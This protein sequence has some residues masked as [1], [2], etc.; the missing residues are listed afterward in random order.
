MSF[1]SWLRSARKKSHPATKA[2]PAVD[3]RRS[4]QVWR[5]LAKSDP[6]WAV[7]SMPEYRAGHMTDEAR[8]AFFESGRQHIDHVLS[9]CSQLNPGFKPLTAFDFGCGVGR[10]SVAMLRNGIKVTAIDI[11]PDMLAICRKNC[12]EVEGSEVQF[13]VSDDTLSGLSGTADLIVS[14]ITFQH[15]HPK[16]G[17]II[18]RSLLQSLN[19][20]GMFSIYFLLGEGKDNGPVG[21]GTDAIEVEIEMNDYSLNKIMGAVESCCDSCHFEFH[22][23]GN[24]MGANIYGRKR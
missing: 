1:T 13:V 21:F 17:M 16:R 5:E 18:F 10:L 8:A 24:R 22:R 7:L 12:E 14:T 15:I 11:S 4:D 20:G 19:S 6:Y 23:M 3:K 2:V 9:K